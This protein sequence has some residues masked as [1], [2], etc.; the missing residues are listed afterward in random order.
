VLGKQERSTARSRFAFVQL[1]DPSGVYEVTLFAELLGRVRELL[2]S[3]QPL[4]VEGDVRLD[5]DLV[6]VQASSLEALD[7]ALAN[8]GR[9]LDSQIEIRLADA[10]AV[11]GLADLLGPHG[12][13]SA[14]V[15]VILPLAPTEEVAIELGDAHRLALVRRIDL[16]RR[17]GVV[18]VVDL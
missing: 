3:N 9:R 17:A 10:T 14:R 2:E 13:G 6:K 8:G 11:G 1:S 18:S 16:E 15:R 5:G 12:D 7:A 4:L